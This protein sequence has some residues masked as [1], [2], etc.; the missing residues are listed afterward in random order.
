MVAEFYKKVFRLR[1]DTPRGR[2][3]KPARG[4][5]GTLLSET[6]S[7]TTSPCQ[8]LS[9]KTEQQRLSEAGP[10]AWSHT[11]QK[12]Q[13]PHHVLKT[14]T[15][16]GL[17]SLWGH[18][19]L[20][21]VEGSSLSPLTCSIALAECLTCPLWGIQDRSSCSEIEGFTQNSLPCDHGELSLPSLPGLKFP[22]SLS[23]AL[24]FSRGNKFIYGEKQMGGNS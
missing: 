2:G 20:V 11:A 24:T 17:C 12:G 15:S 18:L 13:R 6:P 22:L 14:Y 5:V 21:G 8:S 3:R 7:L 23:V 9:L 16:C 1:A 4:R 10:P 19:A